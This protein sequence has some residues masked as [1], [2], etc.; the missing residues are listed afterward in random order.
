MISHLHLVISTKRGHAARVVRRSL[1]AILTTEELPA[2][3]HQTTRE[4]ATIRRV[5]LGGIDSGEEH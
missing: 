4:D 1:H 5:N 3:L 2:L